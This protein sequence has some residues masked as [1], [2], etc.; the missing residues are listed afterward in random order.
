MTT[1]LTILKPET[2][3]SF[4]VPVKTF[5]EF[6]T[7]SANV[8]TFGGTEKVVND[9][10]VVEDTAQVV[11]WYDPEITSDCRVKMIDGAEYEILGN[12]ENIEMRNQV[13]KFKIRRL[14]GGA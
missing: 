4:G 13:M 2:T 10:I 12:P 6:V 1:V 8:K 11:T 5:H 7:V 14:C 3:Y 9:M